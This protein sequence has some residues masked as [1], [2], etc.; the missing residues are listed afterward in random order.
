MTVTTI[1]GGSLR[2][3]D[4]GPGIYV[5]FLPA[6]LATGSYRPAPEATV[7]GERLESIPIAI[8]Q[9]KKGVSARKLVV[10]V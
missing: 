3:N 1:W 9:L 5:D 4:V 7:V 2:D 10:T 6:A 8:Q